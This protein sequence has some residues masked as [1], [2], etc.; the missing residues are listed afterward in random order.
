M[1]YT[2]DDIVRRHLVQTRP[3][4]SRV[5]DQPIVLGDS[6]FVRFSSGPVDPSSVVVKAERGSTPTRRTVTLVN[7]TAVISSSPIVPGSVVVAADTSLCTVYTENHDY[8]IDHAAGL[9]HTKSGGTLADNATI[10]VWSRQYTLYTSGADY[11]LRAETGEIKRLAGGDI[12]P[13]ETLAVDYTPLYAAHDD[14][15]ISAAVSEANSLIEHDID[16]DRA[17][18][19]DPVLQACATYTALS[20]VARASAARVLGASPAEDRS[21]ATWMKLA[22]MFADRADILLRK[23]RPPIHGPA[24]PATT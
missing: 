13:A 9:L 19:A 8:V 2:T 24:A 22:E 12:A 11:T 10:I 5:T 1:S 15:L 17:F 6:S 23:F 4:Q 7:G 16:P 18:G 21:A 20:I 3:V 14:T